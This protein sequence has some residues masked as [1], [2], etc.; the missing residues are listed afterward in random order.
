MSLSHPYGEAKNAIKF[1]NNQ[2]NFEEDEIGKILLHPDVKDRE[3]VIFAIVGSYR[4]GKS[5]FMDYCL[6]FM[7]ANYRSINFPSNPLDNKSN[8]IGNADDPLKGFSWRSGTS[9][10]TTGITFWSDVFLYDPPNDD[11]MAILLVDSQGL[12][13]P[14]TSTEE[15]MKILSLATLFSSTLILNLTNVIQE[16]QLQYLQFTTEYANYV[17]SSSPQTD[18]KPFQKFLFLIRDW[19]NVDDY[20]FGFNG[21]QA[22]LNEV[23]KTTQTQNDDLRTVRDHIRESFDKISCCLM[24]YPGKQVATSSDY[25]GRWSLMDDDFLKEMK[26]L[27]ENFF[28]PQNVIVKKIEGVD[29]KAHEL[30]EYFKSYVNLFSMPGSIPK[31]K[32][33]YELTVGKFLTQIVN[34]CFDVYDQNLS[35][36]NNRTEIDLIHN[37]AQ[38]KALEAF[39]DAKK[40]GNSQD[41]QKY[42]EFLEQKIQKREFEWKNSMKIHFDQLEEEQRKAKE[43]ADEIERLRKQ[44]EEMESKRKAE[45]LQR[46]LEERER[47]I[48]RQ[49]EELRLKK[50]Q[51][52]AELQRQR[53]A[54]EALRRE[55]E[56]QQ[57]IE[58]ERRRLEEEQRRRDEESKRFKVHIQ[59]LGINFTVPKPKKCSLM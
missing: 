36:P 51:I 17:R 23:L 12:F 19:Q 46:Q 53:D 13:D 47:E 31:P 3:V 54:E 50:L 20:E 56:R 58:D 39:S 4:R 15:N 6:R 7:Y 22:Y 34:K 40:M 35:N 24:P 42:K 30:F 26:N 8:W 25:D 1:S 48:A 37:I 27:I 11:P 49:Q 59:E 32:S 38:T 33:L 43:A 45:E 5:F 14:E 57:Q 9:R 21:G 52:E 10:D 55:R 28:N 2:I 16:D 41:A 18:I 29:V 44:E